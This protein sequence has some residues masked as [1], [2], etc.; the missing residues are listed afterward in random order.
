[1]AAAAGLLLV[2]GLAMAVSD[3]LHGS[4]RPTRP[5]AAIAAPPR[6]YVE[7]HVNGGRPV[8]RSTAT[9]A[10]TGTVPVPNTGFD[11]VAAE[12]NGIFFV[13]A[14]V[15]GLAGER[16]YRF[17]VT[18]SGRVSGFSAVPG[19]LLGEGDWLADAIAV[20][21][22][23]SRVAV[24]FTYQ[25][26]ARC[27]SG[28]SA[29]VQPPARTDYIVVVDVASGSQ[30]VW[31]GGMAERDSWFNIASLSWTRNGRELVFLAQR[32]GW[33][34]FTNEICLMG[35]KG[36]S[37]RTAEVW[38]LEPASGGGRLSSGH[39]LFRQPA[40]YPYFTQ[41]LINPNGSTITAVV[42]TGPVTG[43][44]PDVVPIPDVVSVEQISV[45]TGRLQRVL[46]RRDYAGA[47]GT[48]L[49]EFVGLTPGSAGQR[50]LL[51]AGLCGSR[52]A[53][54]SNGWIDNGRLVPLP[55]SDG[56]LAA[57]AW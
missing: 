10:V 36:R 6:Y 43:S 25:S 39:I 11:D 55:P 51:H 33:Q 14:F 45:A 1:V 40:S 53:G 41:A 28:A 4:G 30:S 7:Q 32:C 20:S 24:A 21:P 42:Q 18:G 46:Y 44:T 34:S 52:C 38:A 5:S 29:C 47:A 26:F 54:G 22:D 2:V 15:R 37:S 50:W 35:Q 31:R 16:L 19:R 3:Q 8:V 23:G 12:Q 27:S 9:G 17:R 48:I 13:V 49:L 56:V 57:E